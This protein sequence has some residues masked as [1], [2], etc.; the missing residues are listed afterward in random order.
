MQTKPKKPKKK[1]GPPYRYNEKCNTR[2]LSIPESLENEIPGETTS[3]QNK[4]IIGA[5]R[6]VFGDHPVIPK[7]MQGENSNG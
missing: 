1:R 5:L 4:A 2:Q 7:S 3:D 6:L